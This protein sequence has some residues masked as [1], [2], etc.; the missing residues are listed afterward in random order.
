MGPIFSF[1]SNNMKNLDNNGSYFFKAALDTKTQM[2][3]RSSPHLD[4]YLRKINFK[5]SIIIAVSL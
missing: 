1:F 3:V 4:I 2:K 5:R